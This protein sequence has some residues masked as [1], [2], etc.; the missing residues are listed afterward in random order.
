MISIISS[1]TTE[2]KILDSPAQS[3]Q[4]PQDK[5]IFVFK[6]LITPLKISK[7]ILIFFI[8]LK[9]LKDLIISFITLNI[10]H[11]IKLKGKCIILN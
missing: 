10:F 6:K 1:V 7:N 11:S 5:S 9:F 2:I 4:E 8:S 3:D